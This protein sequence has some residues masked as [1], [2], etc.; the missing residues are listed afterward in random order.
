MKKKVV[1]TGG[2]GFIGSH[3]VDLLLSKKYKVHVIDNLSGGHKKNL[4]HHFK[5]PLLKFEK[6]DIC[7]LKPN[8]NFK[9][10]PYNLVKS[11]IPPNNCLSI[12]D[13]GVRK[14]LPEV[15]KPIVTYGVDFDA[16]YNAQIINQE[17]TK[18]WVKV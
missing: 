16:D 12:D 4:N 1:V 2:A 10:Y 11:S 3:M 6:F 17:T 5:N 13:E 15:T 18:T 7:K 9:A 14:V 8:N